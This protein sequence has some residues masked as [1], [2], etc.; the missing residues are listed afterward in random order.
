MRL[1]NVVEAKDQQETVDQI[2]TGLHIHSLR[3]PGEVIDPREAQL[4]GYYIYKEKFGMVAIV[5]VVK[6]MSENGWAGYLFKVRRVL[7]SP[8]QVTK[9]SVFEAG[10]Y[11]EGGALP[12]SWHL[13]PCVSLL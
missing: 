12:S 8:W 3:S 13:E 4:G 2:N 5:K 7:F 9:G 10:Y 11:A 1:L 6:T